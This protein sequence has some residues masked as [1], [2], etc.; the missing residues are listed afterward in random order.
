MIKKLKLFIL[1]ISSLI[2]FATPLVVAGTASADPVPQSTI[3]GNVCSGGNL[4]VTGT[5]T[6]CTNGSDLNTFIAG[7]INVISVIVGVVAVLMIIAGGFRYMTS[8]GKEESV[9]GA[10]NMILYAI[11]GLVIV[12]LA[13]VIV[14]FILYRVTT[15]AT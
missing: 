5:Q 4:D 3:N 1:S 12:A 2:M 9:K 13:Q 11:I 10:K 6:A 8:G 7:V 15:S 14:H